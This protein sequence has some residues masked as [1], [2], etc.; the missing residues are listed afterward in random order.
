MAEQFLQ[1]DLI[2]LLEELAAKTNPETIQH[3]ARILLLYNAGQD[4]REISET[5]GLSPR[6]VRFWRRE[7]LDRGMDIF[8]ATTEHKQS[9]ELSSKE[10]ASVQPAP[11]PE[12]AAST[13]IPFPRVRKN[14]GL[15]ADDAM[16]EAG[17]KILRFHFAHM[18]SH[19]NGTRLGED[20]EEL[21]DMRVATRR[22][23]AAFEIFKPFFKQKAVKNHLKGLRA[24]GRALGHVRDLDVFMEKAEHYLEALPEAKRAGLEPLLDT[25][26][27]ERDSARDKMLAHLNSKSYQQFKQDFNEFVSTPGAGARRL[28]GSNPEPDLVRLVAPILV[29][30]NL[31]AVRAYDKIIP[32]AVIEQLHALRIEFKKLRYT[33]EFFR[34]VLGTQSKEVIDDLKTLQDHL[35]DLNDA[36][37]ACQILRKFIESWEE[38]QWALPLQERQ[39]PE[40]VVDYLAAKHAERYKLMITFPEAWAH[41]NRPEFLEN[42]ALAISVL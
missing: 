32:N 25:W 31:A 6:T 9:E 34:E 28:S 11:L 30:T 8:T 21:H 2:P 41:F 29:Y 4:T 42:V 27:Q 24:T 10:H 5:V 14:P 36:N 7:F 15:K 16:A 17:R 40:P 38:R 12:G 3:R 18:L 37:V 23:R 39:N 35:G 1:P 19:E 22:M 33:L 13:R 26:Q 20:I